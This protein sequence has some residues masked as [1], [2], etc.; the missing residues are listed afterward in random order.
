VVWD[1]PNLPAEVLREQIEQMM[2]NLRTA[3]GW[4][5]AQ[6]RATEGLRLA[7]TLCQ[8]WLASGF[9]AETLLW[10]EPMREM[11]SAQTREGETTLLDVPVV[12]RARAL[13]VL[14]SV[15]SYRGQYAQ[16]SA[17]LHDCVALSRELDDR[18]NL[19][20]S[21]AVFGRNLWLNGE[22]ERGA[23]VLEEG[24]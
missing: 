9:Y 6:Y 18:S 16:A 8:F 21:L 17:F 24:L 3:L 5:M 12:L 1:S 23:K 15:A 11:A 2:D 7:V 22:K 13:S 4:W 14:G 20:R 10:L 19:A